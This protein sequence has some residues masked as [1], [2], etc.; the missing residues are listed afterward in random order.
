MKRYF[1]TE[2]LCNPEEHYM[3]KLEGRLCQI[4]TLLVDR[5]KYF[6]I[7]KGRQYGKTTMLGALEKYLKDEY[8]VIALD[9]QLMGAG[10]FADEETFV[11]AF[12]KVFMEVFDLTDFDSKDGLLKPLAEL[13]QKKE[14]GSL[15]ELFVRLSRV[16]AKA[17]K[18]VVLMIDEVDSAANNQVFIDFLAQLRGYYLKRNKAS[19]F[20]SVILAGVYNIKN[21]KL[22]LRPEAEHQYNSPWNIAADFKINMSFSV[23]EIA[24][25]LGEYEADHQTG[26]DMQEM[27]EEIYAYTS[28]Y[29]VLVSS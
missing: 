8:I 14:K 13:A 1:N 4:K 29:P 2:G 22:K 9:F 26:M 23:D 7:N 19:I 25:M 18:P 11:S 6:I 20:Y 15:N 21:L 16:C 10:D 28:G 17:P 12:A 27:A 24:D 5:M 3:V